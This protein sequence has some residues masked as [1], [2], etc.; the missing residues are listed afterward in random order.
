MPKINVVLNDKNG[1]L[2]L[3]LTWYKNRNS[4]PLK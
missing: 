1:L 4:N 3:E 2:F